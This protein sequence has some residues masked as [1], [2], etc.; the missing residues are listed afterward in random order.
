MR[1]A[2]NPFKQDNEIDLTSLIDVVFL[3]I[4]FFM[5]ASTFEKKEELFNITLPK[6]ESSDSQEISR[7][8]NIILLT[9]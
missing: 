3:I 6:A 4:I 2:K 7:E 1:K 9:K 8:A 5:V